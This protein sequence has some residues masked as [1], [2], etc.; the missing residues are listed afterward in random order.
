[1]KNIADYFRNSYETAVRHQN[2][3]EF[4]H[5]AEDLTADILTYL[6]DIYSNEYKDIEKA[7]NIMLIA[8]ELFPWE[9]KIY[10][11]LCD[12]HYKRQELEE[13]EEYAKEAIAKCDSTEP[14]VLYNL[15][16]IYYDLGK[17]KESIN[18]YRQVLN[19]SPNFHVAKY[20]LACSLIYTQNFQDGWELYEERFKAFDHINDIRKRYNYPYLEKLDQLEKGK[21]LLL[22]NEQGLG[23][24]IFSLRYINYFRKNGINILY[25]LD[26]INQSLLKSTKIK[27]IKWHNPSAKIDFVCSFMSFPHLFSSYPIPKDYS[28]LFS[29]WKKP[30]NKIPKVGLV[31]SGSP[32]HPMDYRRSMK[33][34]Q[35]SSIYNM[36]NIEF[37][38]LQK[39]RLYAKDLER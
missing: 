13:A 21:T 36:P 16:C 11:N 3:L 35:L 25:D 27:N 33:L 31:F 5:E 38:L 4:I 15:A 14:I 7:K 12:Y 6:A 2:P 34:S 23:D 18:L 30:K 32:N 17:K 8:K 20:N 22:F 1:M 19:I 39:K 24:V 9:W 29:K 37:H 10:N 26:D 28:L